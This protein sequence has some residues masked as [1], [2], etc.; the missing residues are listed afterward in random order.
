[1]RY[2][3]LA[4]LVFAGL[5]SA[6]TEGFAQIR[7]RPGISLNSQPTFSPYLNLLRTGNGGFGNSAAFNYYGIVR[8]QIDFQNNIAGLQNDVDLN[9][10]A[11]LD[12]NNQSN[13]NQLNTF[14]TGHAAVFLNNG[15]YFL[16]SSPRLGTHGGGG[17]GRGAQGRV[18]QTGAGRAGGASRGRSR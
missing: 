7:P 3:T 13:N 17:Q 9:R 2:C 10:Q 16:N 15:G 14:S 6:P 1:M 18:G 4:L 5:I 12:Q 8:P 11:I